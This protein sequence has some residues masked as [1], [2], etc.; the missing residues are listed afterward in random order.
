MLGVV[1]PYLVV[2]WIID[3][4]LLYLLFDIM[5]S[6]RVCLTSISG[7]VLEIDLG[8]RLCVVCVYALDLCCVWFGAFF[9]WVGLKIVFGGLS[10][11][12]VVFLYFVCV[13]FVGVLLARLFFF[14]VLVVGWC[15]VMFVLRRGILW[16]QLSWGWGEGVFCV[17]VCLH[18]VILVVVVVRC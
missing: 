4:I 6:N 5:K 17:G 3:L 16:C 14:V 2:V 11:L 18:T 15:C 10:R 7:L 1:R 8:F 13:C 9:V 12:I